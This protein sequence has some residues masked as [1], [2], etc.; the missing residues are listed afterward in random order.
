MKKIAYLWA[1]KNDSKRIFYYVVFSENKFD[2][3]ETGE[4]IEVTG[5]CDRRENITSKRYLGDIS[6]NGIKK[7]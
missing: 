4:T 3:I 5:T 6:A 1:P 2:T 7:F